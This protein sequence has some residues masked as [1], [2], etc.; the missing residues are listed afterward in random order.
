MGDTLPAVFIIA[1]LVLIITP[2]Q[3]MLLVMSRSIS[4]GARAGVV[5][6]AGVSTGLLGHTLLASLGLGAL[7]M[8]SEA[9]FTAVKIAGAA[10]LVYMGVTHLWHNKLNIDIQNMSE[11]PLKKLY[12]Q[13]ALSNL[14][15]P[16]IAIFYFAYLPQFVPA[17][18]A[19]PTM[20]LLFL[21]TVFAALTFMVKGPVGFTAGV[22][23][24]WLRSRPAVSGWINRISGF[25]LIAL[26]LRLAFER[27]N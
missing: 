24:N 13:G 3:D 8:A 15:N 1:S 26:G 4:Q 20:R 22:L 17:G 25:V 21:G 10:Y 16:K 12:F 7:L 18:S 14:T 11:A 2:G 6:A 23:S 19:N 27:R 9:L 5:T